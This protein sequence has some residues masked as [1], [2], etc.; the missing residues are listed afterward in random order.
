MLWFRNPQRYRSDQVFLE[1]IV[2][3]S[4]FGHAKTDI[5]V[6]VTV[7]VEKRSKL[8]FKATNIKTDS[9]PD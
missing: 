3:F 7:S 2:R 8:E 1:S 4:E 5:L 9:I 6:R